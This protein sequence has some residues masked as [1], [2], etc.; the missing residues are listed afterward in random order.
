VFIAEEIEARNT[1]PSGAV[2][3]HVNLDL[4]AWI[5]GFIAWRVARLRALC[6]RPDIMLLPA[7]IIIY[8]SYPFG[9][10]KPCF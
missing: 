9:T 5:Y 3:R 1:I 4:A 7:Q 6:P 10:V 2:A 8:E